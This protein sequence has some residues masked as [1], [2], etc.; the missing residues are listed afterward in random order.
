M[1]SPNVS[2]PEALLAEADDAY[3]R[4]DWA[5]VV[6]LLEPCRHSLSPE[7]RKKFDV[8]RRALAPGA[9][10]CDRRR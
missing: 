7:H 9:C 8:A 1:D 10:G 2:N 6:A 5:R 3:E 4:R